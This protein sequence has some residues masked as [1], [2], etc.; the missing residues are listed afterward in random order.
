MR[1]PVCRKSPYGVTFHRCAI[2]VDCTLVFKVCNTHSSPLVPYECDSATKPIA[3]AYAV[4]CETV[5][6]D[7]Q[8]RKVYLRA[9]ALPCSPNWPEEGSGREASTQQS[10]DTAWPSDHQF[11]PSVLSPLFSVSLITRFRCHIYTFYLF[12]SFF[13]CHIYSRRPRPPTMR[14][15]AET[16]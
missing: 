6:V 2:G 10:I 13:R 15:L 1:D 8:R 5:H 3:I 7:G 11:G 14:T 12:I 16:F 4:S 9:K